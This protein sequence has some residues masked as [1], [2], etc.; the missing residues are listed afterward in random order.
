MTLLND[1]ARLATIL[2]A[3]DNPAEQHLA[4]RALSKGVMRCDLRTVSDGE[5]AMDYLL[6]RDQYEDPI[7]APR[8]DLVLLDLNMPKLDGRQVLEQMKSDPAINTI[9]VV[10]LTTST[11]E[12]DV[13]RSYELGCNSFINKPVD[14]HAF[15]EAL[16]QLGSYWLKLVVLPPL[17]PPRRV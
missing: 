1:Q 14:V 10:V 13:V 15:L 12:Q 7:A 3:E 9:P 8:P 6:R 5:E 4:R 16:E 17:E 11:H 2:L